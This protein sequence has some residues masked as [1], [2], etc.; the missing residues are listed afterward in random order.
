MLREAVLAGEVEH[1][2]ISMLTVYEERGARNVTFALVERGI[3]IA[4]SHKAAFRLAFPADVAER[5]FP[6]LYPANAG[7][8]T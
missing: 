7:M 6:N 8:R 3:L 5:W 4:T 2:K 1:S